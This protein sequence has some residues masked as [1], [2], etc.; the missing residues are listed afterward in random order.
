MVC[1]GLR[2]EKPMNAS[3]IGF[4]DLLWGF[5]Q[6]CWS[7]D[8]NLRPKVAEVVVNLGRAAANWS[9]LMPPCVQVVNVV[10]GPKGEGSDTM[11]FREFEIFILLWCCS[12]SN[13]T[14]GIF[15]P[16]CSFVDL[17]RTIESRTTSELFNAPRT[18]STQHTEPSQE[19]FQ[20]A[21]V[22][23]PK[24]PQPVPRPP[25]QPRLEEPHDDL[26]MAT[27]PRFN[28]HFDPPPSKLPRKKRR[29]F[30][31]YV[32]SKLPGTSSRQSTIPSAQCTEST[33]AKDL[34]SASQEGGDSI[35]CGESE[36]PTPL[37][38]YT[39]SSDTGGI[40]RSPE[41]L[42]SS[43]DHPP[44]N[45]AEIIAESRRRPNQDLIDRIDAVC[46]SAFRHLCARLI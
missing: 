2:P 11:E 39:P 32:K 35:R 27:H 29:G 24:E 16:S 6:R 8:R 34:T 1:K 12:S 36:L 42:V 26:D 38:N 17:G 9:G 5:V 41:E 19:E 40:F 14:A 18:A 33:E 3:S 10:S 21:V 31:Y 43:P 37:R 4:S 30:K 44:L 7:A 23:P 20:E 28:Q 22:K 25:I 13:G 15:L 46:H 45:V